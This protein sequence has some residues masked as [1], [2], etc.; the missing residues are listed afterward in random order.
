MTYSLQPRKHPPQKDAIK[1][2]CHRCHGSGRAPCP[3]CSGR[4]EVMQGTDVNGAPIFGQCE[5]C[6][7]LKHVRCA[8]C[9]GEGWT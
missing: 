6:Y 8:H 7:G 9:S 4:G 1:R 5:G 3:I 2:R